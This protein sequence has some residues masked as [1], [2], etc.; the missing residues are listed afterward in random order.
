MSNKYLNEKIN[1]MVYKC[2]VCHGI[3]TIDSF[4]YA[5][6]IKCPACKGR[7]EIEKIVGP[8]DKE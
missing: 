1:M 2:N 7:G 5:D 4:W 3:G 8:Q 6:P